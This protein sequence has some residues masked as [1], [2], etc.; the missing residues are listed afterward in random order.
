V[1]DVIAVRVRLADGG[2]RYFLTFGR[3]QDAVD[4]D[5]VCELVLARVDGFALGG[6]PVAAELCGS[7]RDPAESRDAPY[8]FE[9]LLSISR[10]VIPFSEGY[11]AWR[12]QIASEMAAGK[13]LYY[14][15]SS[16]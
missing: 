16:D 13:R 10:E 14:C 1:D 11:E 8:F 6:E 4:P 12:A 2:E 15:G 3:I 5:P 7:L 9:C